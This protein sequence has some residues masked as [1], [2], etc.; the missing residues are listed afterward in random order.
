VEA[1]AIEFL[2]RGKARLTPLGNGRMPLDCHV[3]PFDN[4]QSKKE[5][6]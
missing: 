6:V 3:T 4:S 2:R 1:V 5:G